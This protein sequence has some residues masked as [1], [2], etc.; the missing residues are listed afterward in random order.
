MMSRPQCCGSIDYATVVSPNLDT[1]VNLSATR[2]GTAHGLCVWFD[3][4]LAEGI[5]FSNSPEK[6]HRI[7]GNA[8]FPWPEPVQLDA[9]D[10]MAVKLKGNLI[11]DEYLWTWETRVHR[12]SNPGEVAIHFRQSDFFGEPMSLGK[13]RKQSADHVPELNDDGRIDRVI[14]ML[15]DERKALGEIALQLASQFPERFAR[16]QDALT[17]VGEM[18]TRYSR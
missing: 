12:I 14:L 8:F 11:G 6:P 13:L 5:H 16:W 1:S 15:M 10:M 7:Y 3:T 17:R 2:A 9:G 4:T 18:S